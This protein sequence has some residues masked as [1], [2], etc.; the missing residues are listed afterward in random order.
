[1]RLIIDSPTLAGKLS[2]VLDQARVTLGSDGSLRRA[3]GTTEDMEVEPE[4]GWFQRLLVRIAS[5]L[6]GEWLL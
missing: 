5:W 1:M 4:T 6:P 2:R 3:D